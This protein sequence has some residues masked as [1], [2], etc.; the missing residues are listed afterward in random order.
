MSGLSL[1]KRAFVMTTC[2]VSALSVAGCAS[3]D[4]LD[5]MFKTDKEPEEVLSSFF[6]LKGEEKKFWRRL[7]WGLMKKLWHCWIRA[8]RSTI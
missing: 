5:S 6:R 8:R 3:T 1:L 7:I 2:A 4:V